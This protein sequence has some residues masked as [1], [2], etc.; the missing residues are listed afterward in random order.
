MNQDAEYLELEMGLD[1]WV[2]TLNEGG[3]VRVRALSYSVEGVDYVFSAL[4]RGKPN[5]NLDLVWV[6]TS[7][8]KSVDGPHPAD[9]SR[10]RWR[11]GA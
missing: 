11:D 2:I 6:P 8:V 1:E 4:E 10:P 5:T 9:S 3:Q 7:L